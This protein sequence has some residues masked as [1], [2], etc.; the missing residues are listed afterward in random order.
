M[1]LLYRSNYMS[2]PFEEAL[3]RAQVPY[4]I[5]GDVGFY[6]RAEIKDALALLRLAARPDDYQSDEAFPPHGQRPR[7]RSRTEGRWRRSTTRRRSACCLL[8]QGLETAKLPPKAWAHALGFIEA[9][10][11]VTRDRTATLADQLSMLVD[12]TGYRAML[13]REP[14]GGDRRPAGEPAG[15]AD[16]RGRVPQH[17]RAARPRGACQRGP[18]RDG[19]RAVCS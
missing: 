16:A 12:R 9:I 10:R 19:R 15:A 13:A 6:Q 17:H 8:F 1:A 3:M 4:V 18:R 2:R 11:S 7:Q 14:C 5:V